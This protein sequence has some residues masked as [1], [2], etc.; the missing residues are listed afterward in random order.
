M[1]VVVLNGTLLKLVVSV[2]VYLLA[3]TS[4]LIARGDRAALPGEPGA[5][6]EQGDGKGGRRRVGGLVAG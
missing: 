3:C 5:H 6:P 1:F 4:T 2:L